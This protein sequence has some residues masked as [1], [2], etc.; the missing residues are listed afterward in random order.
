MKLT[1]LFTLVDELAD[2]KNHYD[3]LI[4]AVTRS[5]NLIEKLQAERDDLNLEVGA[6]RAE[7]AYRDNLVQDLKGTNAVLMAT[8]NEYAMLERNLRSALSALSASNESLQKNQ[9]ATGM[10]AVPRNRAW[11]WWRARKILH[12]NHL[13]GKG[14][15]SQAE[16]NLFESLT[17]LFEQ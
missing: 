7:L 16:V 8:N 13:A 3:E 9:L 2:M 5:Q 17:P 4:G 12:V 14:G 6:L 1:E 15:M 10:V 11:D